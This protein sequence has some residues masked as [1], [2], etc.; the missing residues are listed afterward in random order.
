MTLDDIINQPNKL[1]IENYFELQQEAEKKYGKSTIIM[2][3]VG[4]FFEIYSCP[5]IGKAQEV[6]KI[7]NILLTRKN[8]N[9]QEISLK[10]PNLCG[11]PAVSLDKHLER[12]IS[13]DIWTVIMVKQVGTS[14]NITRKIDRI[15]SPGTNVDFIKNDTYNFI[16]SIYI[17]K[18]SKDILYGG[19]SLIDLSTGKIFVYENFGTMEDKNIVIDEIYQLLNTYGCSEI[20]ISGDG[21]DDAE[22]EKII[23]ELN[24]KSISYTVKSD[25]DIKKSLNVNYQNELLAKIFGSE[26]FLSP[27]EEIDIERYPNALNSLIVILDF[28]IDHDKK[29]VNRLLKPEI[30]NAK[31]RLYIGNNALK[32]LNISEDNGLVKYVN[33][34][35]TAIGRRYISEQLFN[36]LTD[37]VEIEKRYRLSGLFIK[38]PV[39][40]EISSL[41]K[42]FY[43]IERIWRKLVI[44]TISPFEVGNLHQ[45]L[46]RIKKVNE[47]LELSQVTSNEFFFDIALKENIDEMIK[48]IESSFSLELLNMF[49]LTNIS[50]NFIQRNVSVEI[51]TTHDQ[52]NQAY[53]RIMGP[54][55]GLEKIFTGESV[56]DV[57]RDLDTYV[58]FDS[59]RDYKGTNVSILFND[60]EGFCLEIT[61]KRYEANKASIEEF[62]S[63]NFAGAAYTVKQL[64]SSI[65]FYFKE[66]ETLSDEIVLLETKLINACKKVFVDIC[67]ELVVNRDT[68]N[69]VVLYV[70]QIDFYINNATLFEK[71]AYVVPEIITTDGS[72]F[73]ESIDLRHAIVERINENELYIPNDIVLG[74]KEYISPAMKSDVIFQ[75]KEC[76]NG[77]LLYG[78]NSSGKSTL[79]KSLGIA[80]IMAQSGFFVP[81]ASFRYALFES[82]FTRITGED[83]IYNGK[84]TFAIELIDLKNI[85]NRANGRTL[86]IGDEPSK[87]TESISALAIVSST[88]KH[89]SDRNA[90][91]I[92][93][94]HMH[95]LRN[96]NEVSEIDSVVDVHLSVHYEE[97]KDTLIY[98]RKLSPGSGSSIY[99]LEFA[100]YLK[101][102]KEFLA[103]AYAI[104]KRIATDLDP[105]QALSRNKQSTYNR[106]VFVQECA[107][108]GEQGVEIHHI[109]E[110][111]LANDNGTIGHFH[112]NHKANLVCLCEKHHKAVHA[113]TLVIEGIKQTSSGP[114]VIWS[115]K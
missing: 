111:Q 59:P 27:I 48:K 49:S 73:V 61:N 21:L 14:P 36:P 105:I 10:N 113:G 18:T 69:E 67:G 104:R 91:F 8:K 80:I 52:V 109:N 83:D 72:G 46:N 20:V 77:L 13:E 94:T 11:I 75:D 42:E 22:K 47:I 38:N 3:E 54:V 25:K 89:L 70:S 31:Q 84:S 6:S 19:L 56:E 37:R 106:G 71:Y 68:I 26:T 64:K 88:V 45:S 44:G 101:L 5:G 100:K 35:V 4:S 50:K 41:L 29:I 107:I 51:D 97:D 115:E 1:L 87:G 99:G 58:L 110:Q 86:I 40:T 90:L 81:A 17:E 103:T 78:L 74:K 33:K 82:I 96:V 112:K 9:I 30:I 28:I 114:Q 23:A 108:C 12:I 102:N 2:I 32:Q 63:K 24:L 55:I 66:M 65:K 93:A 7:L 60:T 43:D 57:L 39:K 85:F 62:F 79:S 95:D 98:N 92:F 53:K 16:G 34:G 76:V 15:I